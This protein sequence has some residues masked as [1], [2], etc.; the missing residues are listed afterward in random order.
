VTK[1]DSAEVL[2]AATEA[3]ASAGSTSPL[4]WKRQGPV[5]KVPWFQ[6]SEAI[7]Q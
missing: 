7:P 3:A 1:N 5:A 4:A 6:L 2:A